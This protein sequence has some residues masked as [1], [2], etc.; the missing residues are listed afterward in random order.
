M[1]TNYRI[2][3]P[4]RP[5]FLTLTLVEWVDLFTREKYKQIIIDSLK[6]SIQNKGL[7]LYAYVIMSSHVHLIASVKNQN[8]DLTGIIR[9]LKRFTAREIYKQLKEDKPESRRKW[10][11]GV[12][13]RQGE[14]SS[15]NQKFK[16]WRHENHPV[17][18]DS[19]KI[20]DERLNYIHENPIRAGICYRAEDYV[21]SSASQYAGMEGLLDV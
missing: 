7:V 20:M 5:H 11:L 2:T 8:L 18:L 12:F 15:S 9:D 13:E 14:L 4:S 16:I 10:L 17:I 6:F 1:S 3:D 21:Y 19:N